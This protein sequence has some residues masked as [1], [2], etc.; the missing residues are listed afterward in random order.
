MLKNMAVKPGTLLMS[1]LRWFISLRWI[2]G[3]TVLLFALV[4]GAFLRWYG[5]AGAMAA[6]GAAIL[7][8]NAWLRLAT[9]GGESAL[10]IPLLAIAAA[11]IVVD[12][13]ALVLLTLWTGG[14]ASPLM[15]F[16]VLHMIFASLML[17]RR[18]AYA[19]VVVAIGLALAG[20]QFSGELVRWTSDQWRLLAGWTAS[21][22]LAVYL[23]N[24][25]TR[26]L[27]RQRRKLVR[28]NRHIRRIG[29]RLRGHQELMMRQEKMAAMGHMAAG[30]THEIANPLASMDALLQL[31][32]AK[33]GK[34]I[35]REHPDAPAAGWARE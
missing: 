24:H 23:A 31:L 7:L 22:A 2:A 32:Q 6:L 30:I 27:R 33:A 14:I 8:C 1:Q 11:Q 20:F 34:N 12:L 21:L 10:R 4:D 17:P 19:G 29:R 28:Q 18:M 5:H 16:Y 15:G 25:I 26:A 3:A 35:S 9:L 13:C